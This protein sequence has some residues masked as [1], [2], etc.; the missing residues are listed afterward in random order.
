[1]ISM[2]KEKK[3]VT[4]EMFRLAAHL[5]SSLLFLAVR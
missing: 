1:M 4:R 2:N 5:F 3:C